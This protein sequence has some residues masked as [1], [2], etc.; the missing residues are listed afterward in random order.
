MIIRDDAKDK[1]AEMLR[2]VSD[3]IAAEN[4]VPSLG[5][6]FNRKA[7]IDEDPGPV[8]AFFKPDQVE[9]LNLSWIQC[10]EFKLYIGLPPDIS[11]RF[12]SSALGI[13]KENFNFLD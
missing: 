6:A 5:W 10:H 13:I 2:S 7:G 8:L 3:Y 9:K 1:I 4:V 11:E 12:K